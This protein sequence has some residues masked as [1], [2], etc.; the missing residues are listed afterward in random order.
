MERWKDKKITCQ[1]CETEFIIEYESGGIE[2]TICP[3]CGHDL[4]DDHHIDD[5]EEEN[6]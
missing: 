1:N 4:E 6:E 2:P 3:F 5:E